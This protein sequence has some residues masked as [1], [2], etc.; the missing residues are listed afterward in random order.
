MKGRVLD[1]QGLPAQ[2]FRRAGE[3]AKGAAGRLE[4]QEWDDFACQDLWRLARQ[5]QPFHFQGQIKDRIQVFHRELI[6]WDDIL[7]LKIP[8]DRLYRRKRSSNDIAR[9]HENPSCCFCCL[10]LNKYEM[11]A[12]WSAHS[13]THAR[14]VP[15][16]CLDLR[17]RGRSAL[18]LRWTMT[19]RSPHVETQGP[20][21]KEPWNMAARRVRALDLKKKPLSRINGERMNRKSWMIGP[22]WK[23]ERR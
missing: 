17:L 7:A 12:D 15:G 14:T 9:A 20:G 13:R 18:I 5:N 2:A 1:I 22:S 11:M 19:Q 8:V 4:E 21:R 16:T 6:E 3:R 10:S 23:R